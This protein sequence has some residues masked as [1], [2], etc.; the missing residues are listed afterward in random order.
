MF[1]LMVKKLITI[2]RKLFLLIWR[3]GSYVVQWIVGWTFVLATLV[4][5]NYNWLSRYNWNIV[6]SN[7][8]QG[9]VRI[10]ALSI[11]SHEQIQ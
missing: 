5:T 6:E 4:Q 7:I 1:K 3:Y 8:D 9:G 11:N 2:L 10:V